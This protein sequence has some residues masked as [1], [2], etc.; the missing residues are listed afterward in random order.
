MI[1][2]DLEKIASSL[3]VCCLKV[4][5]KIKIWGQKSDHQLFSKLCHKKI[6]ILSPKN[7]GPFFLS[8]MPEAFSNIVIDFRK[9]GKR[10]K[11]LN[12]AFSLT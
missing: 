2:K 7:I 6:I 5:L 9:E 1:F 10:S 11:D 8:G 3:A 12:N 4:D